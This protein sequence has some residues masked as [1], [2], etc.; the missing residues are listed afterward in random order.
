MKIHEAYVEIRA[1]KTPLTTGLMTAARETETAGRTAGARFASG[2]GAASAGAFRMFGA[3]LGFRSLLEMR[4]R[5]IAELIEH[6]SAQR[7]FNIAMGE[8]KEKAEEFVQGLTKV[9]YAE[10]SD[11]KRMSARYKMLYEAFG[12]PDLRARQMAMD[13]TKLTYQ[14][15]T[16]AGKDAAQVEETLTAAVA[17]RAMGLR[18]YGMSLK[19]AAIKEYA[20]RTGL[21]A[22]GKEMSVLASVLARYGLLME[23]SKIHQIDLAKYQD[24]PISRMRKEQ[25]AM[26]EFYQTVGLGVKGTIGVLGGAIEQINVLKPE[27]AA[28]RIDEFLGRAWGMLEIRKERGFLSSFGGPQTLTQRTPHVLEEERRREM[29][30]RIWRHGDFENPEVQ[31]YRR[32][33]LFRGAEESGRALKRTAEAEIL[34]KGLAATAATPIVQRPYYVSGGQKTE[35]AS[36]LE[37]AVT[38]LASIDTKTKQEP[39]GANTLMPAAARSDILTD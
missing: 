35:E 38:H 18:E 29:A 31:R 32:S 4:R 11:V 3:Y 10:E 8:G 20:Y 5:G 22:T 30:F 24:R 34:K 21:V 6:E 1:D 14:I 16:S 15:S 28:G 17:G 19:D 7:L 9:A 27:S 39:G 25:T 26:K 13:M 36:L 2:F 37:Q 12:V 33:I 23:Q